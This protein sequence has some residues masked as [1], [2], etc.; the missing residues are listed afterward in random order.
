MFME[1]PLELPLVRKT[2]VVQQNRQ[3]QGWVPAKLRVGDGSKRLVVGVLITSNWRVGT[4]GV[5]K[6]STPIS[7]GSMRD[8]LSV[9]F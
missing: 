3:V 2:H 8:F 5:W 7:I 6:T 9:H 1:R 4:H